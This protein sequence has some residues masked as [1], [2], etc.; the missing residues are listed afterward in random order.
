MT[1]GS[2]FIGSA[3]AARLSAEG[4]RVIVYADVI[5]DDLTRSSIDCIKGNIFNKNHLLRALEK[6]DAVIH[7]IGLPGVDLAKI[8]PDA[9]FELNV[10]SVQVALEAM[11]QAGLRRFI[12]FSSAAVYGTVKM[13]PITEEV[14]PAPCNIYG[15]HKFI[16]EKIAQSYSASFNFQ[17]T[18]VRPF[19]IYGIGEHGLLRLFITKAKNDRL[20][21]VSGQNQL[22]DFVHVDDVANATASLIKLRHPFEV[23]NIGTGK[24]RRIGH[25]ARMVNK[26]LPNAQ[27]VKRRQLF[28]CYHSV[29]NVSK[30]KDAIEYSPNDTDEKIKEVMLDLIKIN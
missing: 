3:V 2:G 11:R 15:Y 26:L 5:N 1:G 27:I 4:H 23:F 21:P 18:V 19:N 17:V 10:R 25:I 7:A 14:A 16:G 8:N 28:H 22:R 30:I 12:L 13:N 20:I 29:A 24:G 9:S 6:C